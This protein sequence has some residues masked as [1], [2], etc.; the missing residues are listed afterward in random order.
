MKRRTAFFSGWS[1]RHR[2]GVIEAY[3]GM[4]EINRSEAIIMASRAT[5][6]ERLAT[7]LEWNERGLRP[8]LNTL[9]TKSSVF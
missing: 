7:I 5:P 3:M 1:K 2:E 4:Y 9:R 8:K 6:K